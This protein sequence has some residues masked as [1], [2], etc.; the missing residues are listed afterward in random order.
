MNAKSRQKSR[1]LLFV[2]LIYAVAFAVGLL[3]CHQIEHPLLRFF[4]FDLVAT[5]VTFI[6]SVVLG[7]SSVYDPYWSF[8]PMVM[9]I[10]LFIE[11]KAFSCWQLLF[12]L[13]FN[14]WGLRL[15]MN[16][17]LLFPGFSYEDW[18]YRKLRDD[19][20]RLFWQP[21]NFTGIHLVPTLAV[22]GGMLP[23]FAIVKVPLGPWS[24]IGVA[25]ILLGTALE[26]FADRQMH[27]FLRGTPGKEVCRQGLWR[28]SRHPNYLGEISIWLGVYLTMLPYA[29]AYWYYGVGFVGMLLLFEVVSI[30]MMEKRQLARR[31]DYARYRR[32]TSRLLLL[33]PQGKK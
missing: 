5:A 9:S 10:W 33:P 27:G 15:T 12:L 19:M 11:F 4:V 3:L 28:Y 23:L 8:T 29:A 20:P 6:F 18:R 14:L 30:P 21:V 24:L 13:V 2:A 7:N 16:W 1:A 17:L 22:F 25:I 26:F 32:E 31:P